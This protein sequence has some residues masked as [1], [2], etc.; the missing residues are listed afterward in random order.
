MHMQITKIGHCAL[1]IDIDNVRVVTD[2]GNWSPGV[3]TLTDIDVI[4]ITHEHSDHCHIPALKAMLGMSPQA[5][6]VCN[7]SVGT[8]L[9]REGIQPSVVGNGTIITHRTVT[10]QAFNTPHEEIYEAI[11]QV[12]A[13]SFLIAGKLY[14]PADS[15]MV[16]DVAVDV[17]AL[18]VAGPWCR[19]TDAIRF[20]IAIAPRIAFPVHDGML[21]RERV[22]GAYAIPA[23]VLSQHEIRFIPIEPGETV[24]V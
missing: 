9:E 23:Q 22:G 2:P 19:I 4:L 8:I 7:S 18:P 24:E 20:A 13:T 6:V 21:M 12:E 17:L 10:F 3:E 11:G 14:L 15:F 1:L 16:P 5:R